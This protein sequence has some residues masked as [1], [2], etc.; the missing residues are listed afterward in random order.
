MKLRC[1]LRTTTEK[2]GYR[3]WRSLFFKMIQSFRI[4]IYRLLYENFPESHRNLTSV[5]LTTLP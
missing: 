5:F 2:G 1:N 4:G 3:I